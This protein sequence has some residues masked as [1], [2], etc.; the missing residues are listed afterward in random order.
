MGIWGVKID[1]NDTFCEVQDELK[2]ALSNGDDISVVANRILS[3]AD[4]DPDRLNIYYAVADILWRCNVLPKTL[5]DKVINFACSGI[6][7]EEWKS[8]EASESLMKRRAVALD[9]FVSRL[10]RP[11]N[12]NEILRLKQKETLPYSG[13]MFWYRIKGTVYGALVLDVQ[14]DYYLIVLSD[15]LH[16]KKSYTQNDILETRVYTVAWFADIELLQRRFCHKVA[17]F[18][19]NDDYNMRYG[20]NIYRENGVVCEIT[21]TN[22]GQR[23]TWRHEY[24]CL[25]WQDKKMKD[26]L[27]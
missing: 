15:A 16:A 19:I 3:D 14:N 7:M 2:E 4:A 21:C 5:L 10:Q 8:L 22:H 25:R 26:F 9:R 13:E 18:D 1:Q 23:K 20:L 27:T 6:D 17:K 11:P 12:D 24:R